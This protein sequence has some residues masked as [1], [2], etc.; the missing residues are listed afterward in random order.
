MPTYEELIQRMKQL[1][2]EAKSHLDH[3]KCGRKKALGPPPVLMERL[4][5]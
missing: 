3:A 1:N 5:A 4:S 2:E